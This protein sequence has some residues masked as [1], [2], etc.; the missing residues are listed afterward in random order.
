MPI[1]PGAMRGAAAYCYR[2]IKSSRLVA[3]AAVRGKRGAQQVPPLA[4]ARCDIVVAGVT[5]PVKEIRVGA[6][7]SLCIEQCILSCKGTTF[8]AHNLVRFVWVRVDFPQATR[9]AILGVCTKSARNV[10]AP[11]CAPPGAQKVA[12]VAAS[13]LQELVN[14]RGALIE[15]DLQHGS[16]KGAEAKRISIWIP[17]W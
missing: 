8:R 2:F 7:A 5:R 14:A 17:I 6:H 15:L 4:V 11:C 10:C 13:C 9:T 16:R 12:S 3:E 1:Q